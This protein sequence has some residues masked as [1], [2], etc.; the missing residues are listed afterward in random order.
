MCTDRL[1]P[2][3]TS[4]ARNFFTGCS[5]MTLNTELV[6]DWIKEANFMFLDLFYP[7]PNSWT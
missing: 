6:S 7:K 1:P 3:F 2:T 4:A 5:N